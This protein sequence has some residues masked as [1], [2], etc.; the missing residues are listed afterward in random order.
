MILLTGGAGYI[1]SHIALALKDRGMPLVV[2]DN[3]VTGSRALV[4]QGVPLVE[5]DCADRA[6]VESVVRQHGVDVVIHCAG[7]ISVTES[8]REP[9]L[10]YNGNVSASVSLFEAALAGGARHILFSST[11][12][13]YGAPEAPML[14]ETL[15]IA[16]V[17]PYASSKAM[18]ERILQDLFATGRASVG[19]LRYFNVAGADPAG[20]AGQISREATHLI[21]I[22]AE[23]AIG[24]RDHVKVTGTDFPTA[25]GTGVRDYI[26]VSDLAVAH[27]AAVERLRLGAPSF[28][29]NIGYGTGASVLEVLDCVDSLVGVAIR[30]EMAPRRPGD[31]ARLVANP[32]LA[33]ALLNWKP[34]HASLAD[35]VRDAVAWERSLAQ[36]AA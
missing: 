28:T 18:V 34:A 26:H 8:V 6:V 11:A 4:P 5:A 24:K 13:V 3:F 22:A 15:P 31:V 21:K 7:L 19:V 17:N 32:A 12:T 30:R 33:R 27:V 16:P 23:A 1:G 2:L 9:L 14:D 20:R 29:A 36:S 35:I 10:Y 25:D